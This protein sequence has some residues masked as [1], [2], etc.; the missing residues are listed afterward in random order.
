MQTIKK[1]TAAGIFACIAFPA[2]AD[3]TAGRKI[4]LDST[5]DFNPHCS[6]T[7]YFDGSTSSS[8]ATLVYKHQ[9]LVTTYVPSS[10]YNPS[11][12]GVRVLDLNSLNIMGDQMEPADLPIKADNKRQAIVIESSN[13]VITLDGESYIWE[14]NCR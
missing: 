11:N 5:S 12:L 2:F 3:T 6:Y 9:L 7:V 14:Y 8:N 1:L 4:D 13:T 10:F